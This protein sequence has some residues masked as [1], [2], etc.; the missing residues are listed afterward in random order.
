M[1]G[2]KIFVTNDDETYVKM[3]HDVLADAGY[4]NVVWHVGK[5]VYHRI[6]AEQPDLILL[7]ISMAN[8]AHGWTNL[9]MLKFA[10]KTRHIP[11]IL[12]STDPRLPEQ[13]A[14]MLAE[15]QVSFLEKPFDLE[16][17][18]DRITSIIGPPQT[19]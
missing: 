19:S 10:P 1:A 4:Q 16:T 6:R 14:E 11:I 12:C 8:P 18:L 2:Q 3:I 17:L 5:G 9:D 15:L 7:D 13:K